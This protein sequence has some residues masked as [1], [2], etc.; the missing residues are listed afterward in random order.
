MIGICKLCQN[1]KEV[2]RRSHLFPNFMYKGIAD[3]KNRMH[4]ISSKEPLKRKTA[5][6]GAI[7]E[8]I[9][10]ADCDNRI[11]GQLERY[12]NNAFYSKPYLTTSEGF[13]QL[14]PNPGV[15]IIVCT[16]LDYPRFK[17][18][19]ESLLWRASISNHSM[20]ADF[21]LSCEQE[22][23]LRLSILNHQ[24]LEETSFPCVMMTCETKNVLTDFVVVDPYKKGMVK[25]FIN[26]FIYTFY[27]GESKLEDHTM[28]L[29]IKP[30]NTM[31]VLKVSKDTWVDIRKSIVAAAVKASKSNLSK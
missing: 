4:I 21:N 24:P 17:L 29:T 8:Y 2:I 18:F 16:N 9:L 5:Q 22:E 6:T 23:Q 3:D 31:V 27:W 1:E 28:T 30:D 26:E 12:A 15:S 7:D 20:F 13:E 11:L 25:F 10:C 14:I 19:L